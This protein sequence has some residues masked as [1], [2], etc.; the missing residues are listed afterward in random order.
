MAKKKKDEAPP[1]DNEHVAEGA[2][3]FDDGEGTVVKPELS[4]ESKKVK[5]TYEQPGTDNMSREDIG[6][7][8]L[9]MEGDE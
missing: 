4:G 8:G 6:K 9:D 7:G 3:Q 2:E 5:P 1:V